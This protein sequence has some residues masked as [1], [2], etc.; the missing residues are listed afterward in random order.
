MS[1]KAPESPQR[2]VPSMSASPRT[3]LLV[4]SLRK[5]RRPVTLGLLTLLLVDITELVPPLLLKGALDVVE[6][7]LGTTGAGEGSALIHEQANRKLL[8][9]ALIYIGIATVQAGCRY[10]WRVLLIHSSMNAA[11]DMRNRFAERLFLLS[12]SFFDKR[13]VGDL[14]SLAT[15][16]VEAVRMALGAGLLTLADAV[17]YILTIPL[18]MF[19]LSPRL[20]LLSFIMMPVIPIFVLY[21]EKQID[22]RYRRVQENF[23]RLS[24]IVQE[25]LSGVRVIKAFARE[26]AQLGRIR[27]AGHEHSQSVLS[28][29]RIN[30]SFGPG[31]DF[32]MSMGLVFLLWLGGPWVVEGTISLGTF[33]AF[34][35]YIQK[36]VW[37]MTAIGFA[38]THY[39]KALASSARLNDV[40]DARSDVEVDEQAGTAGAPPPAP[41]PVAHGKIEFRGLNFAFPGSDRRVL[42]DIHLVIEPGMRVAFVGSIGSGKSAL[43]SLVPRL[44]PCGRGQVFVDDRD[45]LDWRLGELRS[46]IGFVSQEVFLFSEGV[47][48]NIAFGLQDRTVAEWR[49]E[50]ERSSQVAAVHD[51]ILQF[52]AGYATRLGE[53]GL[54]LSGGQKQRLTLA[55]AIAR[56]PSVLVLD[57]AL[58]AVDVRTEAR[59]L[60]DL[61]RRPGRNT[62][63]IA[64]HRISTVR[65]SDWIVVLDR[66]RIAEQGNHAKLL[67]SGEAGIYRRFYDQQRLRDELEAYIEELDS[68]RTGPEVGA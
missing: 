14:M 50:V 17:F 30:A 46:Q 37:P 36:M 21:A 49:S 24:A 7:S 23:S 55:R 40:L 31:L 61:K 1:Q 27:S 39:Q 59:I 20:A 19:W 9:L 38:I 34:Q 67:A 22:R 33:V 63:L 41:H 54:N 45:I 58:S 64:A 62:E 18:A 53:R 29:T 6:S 57:D 11:R 56:K 15:S 5:Y 8:E 25:G 60:S 47:L 51:E 68:G 16:D 42:Q 43:L 26:D 12:Q 4:D 2:Q 32:L 13:K 3:R 66:G 52:E 65:E 35:R 28:L 44:Y 10:L 48:E